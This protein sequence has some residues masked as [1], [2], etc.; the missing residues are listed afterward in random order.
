M[1]RKMLADDARHIDFLQA[2]YP[3]SDMVSGGL[4]AF[5]TANHSE[6]NAAMG[7]YRKFIQWSASTMHPASA[8]F[9][10]N[11]APAFLR[12]LN[13]HVDYYYNWQLRLDEEAIESL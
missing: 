2:C 11:D 1:E 9:S 12:P 13:C 6:A 8:R 7:W 10:C 4:T 3:C 5:D